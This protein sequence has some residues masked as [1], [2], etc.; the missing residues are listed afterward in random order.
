[1]RFRTYCRSSIKNSN[2][3]AISRQIWGSSP[4]KLCV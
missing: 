2:P 3:T 1:M 4:F